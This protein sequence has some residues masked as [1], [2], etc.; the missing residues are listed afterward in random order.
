MTGSFPSR[1]YRGLLCLHTL[2]CGTAG[3]M[4]DGAKTLLVGPQLGRARVHRQVLST[5][6][7]AGCS[8]CLGGSYAGSSNSGWVRVGPHG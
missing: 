1:L 4:K 7:L 3:L 2:S 5:P 8:S 6:S